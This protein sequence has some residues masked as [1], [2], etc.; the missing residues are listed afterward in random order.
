MHKVGVDYTV[1]IN[2]YQL[3]FP[4]CGSEQGSLFGLQMGTERLSL[5]EQYK[6]MIQLAYAY[7]LINLSTAVPFHDSLAYLSLSGP[8]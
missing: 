6:K 1:N 3:F 7:Y 2:V 8:P 4:Q 5:K